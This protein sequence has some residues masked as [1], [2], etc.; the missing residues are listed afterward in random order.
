MK[1]Q[2]KL[3]KVLRKSKDTTKKFLFSLFDTSVV[4]QII[5]GVIKRILIADDWF[6]LVIVSNIFCMQFSRIAV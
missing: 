1:S 4:S 3:S 6:S 5:E 2:S